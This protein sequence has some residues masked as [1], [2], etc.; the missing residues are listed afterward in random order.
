MG[1]LVELIHRLNMQKSLILAAFAVGYAMAQPMEGGWYPSQEDLEAPPMDGD[2]YPSPEDFEEDGRMGGYNS[3]N[4]NSAEAK[5]AVKRIFAEEQKDNTCG[6]YID[7]ILSHSEQ[8]VSGLN[9]SVRFRI[10]SASCGPF[11]CD[12][13]HYVAEHIGIDKV[14]ESNCRRGYD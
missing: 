14:S 13:V 5:R 11:V 4:V 10:A 9:H 12:G 3:G 6:F 7:E 2:W 1:V 8:V